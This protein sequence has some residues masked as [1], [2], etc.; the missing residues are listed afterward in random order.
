MDNSD[1]GQASPSGADPGGSA[2][3][4]SAHVSAEMRD[5]RDYAITRAAVLLQTRERLALAQERQKFYADRHGRANMNTFSVG[6]KVLLST[7]NLPDESV[8]NLQSSKLRPRWIGPFTVLEKIGELDYRL[9]LPTRMRLHPTFYVGL[10]KPYLDPEH[11]VLDPQEELQSPEPI[12]SARSEESTEPEG[13][14]QTGPL[15]RPSPQALPERATMRDAAS[16][17]PSATPT[18]E[19]ESVVGAA[20]DRAHGDRAAAPTPRGSVRTILPDHQRVDR[21][22]ACVDR[23]SDQLHSNSRRSPSQPIDPTATGRAARRTSDTGTQYRASRAPP[24]L[25]DSTGAK[26]WLV[27]Q[28]L[29]QQGAP[30]HRRFLVKWKG[31]PVEQSTWEP[32]RLLRED[33]PDV[34]DAFLGRL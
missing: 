8:T 4:T 14:V 24:P 2:D 29:D 32:E 7:K 11:E 31:Y 20:P 12:A 17:R 19:Q 30:P 16:S 15:A 27:D 5:A 6:D 21:S 9:D 33:V 23:V 13:A 3:N 18:G 26:R 10:L 1:A 34:L 22:R 28:I 25:L